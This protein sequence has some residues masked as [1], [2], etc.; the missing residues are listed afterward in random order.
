MKNP[1]VDEKIE[2]ERNLPKP[3]HGRSD[4]RYDPVNIRGTRETKPEQTSSDQRSPKDDLRQLVLRF[5]PQLPGLLSSPFPQPVPHTVP[6]R[7]HCA[8][9]NHRHQQAREGQPNLPEIEPMVRLEY[10]R[11]RSKEQ[12]QQPQQHGCVHVQNDGHRLM[13]QDLERSQQGQSNRHGDRPRR[14]LNRR[15]IPLIPR[16][17][18]QLFR[19]PGQQYRI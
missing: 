16:F 17:L 3:K 12:V 9:D 15:V 14:P 10:Q 2:G 11:E 1:G 8:C 6:D 5:V 13:Q 19:L 7:R 18:S 4:N